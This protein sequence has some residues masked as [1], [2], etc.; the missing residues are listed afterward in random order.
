MRLNLIVRQE[1][2]LCGTL[3]FARS[4][5]CSWNQ[6]RRW[7]ELL[8]RMKMV[9]SWQKARTL[10]PKSSDE[11]DYLLWSSLFFKREGA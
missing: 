8:R 11:I 3:N 5:Y 7:A 10:E 6:L 9:I 4:L 2:L 1:G